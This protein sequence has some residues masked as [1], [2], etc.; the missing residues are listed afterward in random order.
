MKPA[1]ALAWL[2]LPGLLAPATATAASARAWSIDP[3][4]SQVQFAVR[5]FWFVH[6]R[7]TLPALTG[8]LRRLDTRA[9]IDLAEVEATLGTD[10]LQMDDP[11]DRE[12]ALGPDFFDA[13]RFPA[14]DFA[15]R[16]FPLGQLV[17]GGKLEGELTL[18][19]ESHPVTLALQPS[20]CPRQPLDCVIR[21]HGTI[22]RGAFGMHRMRGVLSDK[23]EL[24]LR[25]VLR[26]SEP[27]AA[28]P[29]ADAPAS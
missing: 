12:R 1:S 15:S 14:I 25:I 6:V 17:S 11:D 23:V 3:A 18:H 28:S 21:V 22:S 5:K 24:D 13:A 2:L 8:T 19:G 10:G 27:A 20:D 7:G 26:A 4:Q 29:G 16:P 9:G